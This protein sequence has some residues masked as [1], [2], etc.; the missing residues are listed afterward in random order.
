MS[1]ANPECVIADEATVASTARVV[2][3]VSQSSQA[4]ARG[5]LVERRR[6][7]RREA[8]ELEQHAHGGARVEAGAHARLERALEGDAAA[9]AADAVEAERGE[10]APQRA[11]GA[12]GAG[13]EEPH[14]VG[15]R[16]G[17]A[18]AAG[19]SKTPSRSDPFASRFAAYMSSSARAISS[20]TRAGGREEHRGA[21][22]RSRTCQPPCRAIASSSVVRRRARSAAAI[23]GVGLGEEEPELVA[24]EPRHRVHRAGARRGASAPP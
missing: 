8:R 1:A 17:D 2:R 4:T 12:L 3:T 24:A 9:V 22:A 5:A 11:L 20:S 14:R 15:L 21:D 10:L 16:A 13:G 7:G 23:G 6:V 19:R 18:P